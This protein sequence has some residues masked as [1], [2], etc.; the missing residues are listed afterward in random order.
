MQKRGQAW[1]LDV[2]IAAMIFLTGII[3]FYLYVIN[4]KT[5]EGIEIEEARFEADLIAASILSEGTPTDWDSSS[6]TK[7][8]ILSG[9]KINETK[10]AQFHALATTQYERTK[11][12]F[13]TRYNYFINSSEPFIINNNAE[14]GIGHSPSP[15][16]ETTLK[17]NRFTTYKNKPVTLEIQVWKP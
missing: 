11:Q 4:Y 15:Q 6:V 10:L 9:E 7:I 14:S 1:G 17:I 3:V 13:G 12:L 16:A 8:G 5:S 2:T